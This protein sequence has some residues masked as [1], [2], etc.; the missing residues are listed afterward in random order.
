[1]L[2]LIPVNPFPCVST[3]IVDALDSL[4]HVGRPDCFE[5]GLELAQELAQ[6]LFQ[7][8]TMA[9]TLSTETPNSRA[10]NVRYRAESST[11][12]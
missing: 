12:A 1:M 5:A 11:P 2:T 6:E 10:R 3:K 8:E 7:P 4:A 9:L